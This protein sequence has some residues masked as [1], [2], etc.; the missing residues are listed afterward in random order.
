MR[1]NSIFIKR[2]LFTG[3]QESNVFIAAC[4]KSGEAWFIDAGGFNRKM[5]D[6]IES[7]GFKPSG[8]FITHNH[9]DHTDRAVDII[10][11][12]SNIAV[13][14]HSISFN[15]KGHIKLT[16]GVEVE[17]GELCGV[18][19]YIPGHTDDMLTLYIEGH[20]FTGDSLFAGSVGGTSDELHYNQQ[21]DSIS[22][23]LLSYPDD[24]IIHPGHGPDSTIGLEKLFNPFL[25][26]H[27]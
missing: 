4:I 23:R 10:K 11:T 14:S 13:Y 24:T 8:L 2:F 16:E 6:C 26:E 21:I 17:I 19:H 1:N 5:I 3:T 20:L 22:K 15:E 9:Y 27:V 18:I 12:W 25:T 7:N